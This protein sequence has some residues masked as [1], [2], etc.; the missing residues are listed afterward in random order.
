MSLF[1]HKLH[2][3][4]TLP[5]DLCLEE[6]RSLL[7]SRPSTSL[8]GHLS[9][10]ATTPGSDYFRHETEVS[11]KILLLILKLRMVP[12]WGQYAKPRWTRCIQVIEEVQFHIM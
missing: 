7:D 11:F 4:N 9:G 10:N 12:I 3:A 2:H 6:R 8:S 1:Q 5:D